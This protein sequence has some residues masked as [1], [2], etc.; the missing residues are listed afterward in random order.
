MQTSKISPML[1]DKVHTG[2]PNFGKHS[3]TAIQCMQRMVAAAA[4]TTPSVAACGATTVWANGPI[5]PPKSN[6]PLNGLRPNALN[7]SIGSLGM[8]A[9]HV[10]SLCD[11]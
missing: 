1:T 4:I 2:Y 5:A 9:L 11:K 3:P 8:A 10:G 6:Q 7:G